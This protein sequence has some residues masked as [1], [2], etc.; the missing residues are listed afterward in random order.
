MIV[1]KIP[2][3]VKLEISDNISFKP[4]WVYLATIR[5]IRDKVF[6]LQYLSPKEEYVFEKVY[7]GRNNDILRM[8]YDPDLSGNTVVYL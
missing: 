3:P 2:F 7:R 5:S 1:I 8:M 4:Q 6:E